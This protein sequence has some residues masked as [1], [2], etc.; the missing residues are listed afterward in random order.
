MNIA[1]V[2]EHFNFP[3]VIL[4]EKRPKHFQ[5]IT[6]PG[7][8]GEMASLLLQSRKQENLGEREKV[9]LAVM[10]PEAAY[11]FIDQNP[12][13][14]IYG[15]YTTTAIT[16]G[17]YVKDSADIKTWDDVK[18]KRFGIS[19][20]GS[21]SELM[22]YYAYHKSQ[23]PFDELKFRVV[24]NLQGARRAFDNDEIDVFL[25]EVL[26]TQSLIESGEWRQVGTVQGDWPG[27]VFVG[28]KQTFFENQITY[29]SFF[30][31]LKWCIREY[32]NNAED[33]APLVAKRF[34]MTQLKEQADLVKGIEGI[35]FSEN[36]DINEDKY[37]TLQ[38]VL[39]NCGKIGNSGQ[40][41]SPFH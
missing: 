6:C 39:K 18:G 30:E 13:F 37:K 17:V 26:T 3:F 4:S 38:E 15:E 35:E 11:T 24:Q 33:W 8:S 20:Q 12:D 7:G 2:P 5:Y 10:L 34:Q 19:R 16:W 29:P 1:G 25:W 14:K 27:F 21:G 23:W 40:N 41:I 36:G 31:E 28:H 9:D 32:A 22:A